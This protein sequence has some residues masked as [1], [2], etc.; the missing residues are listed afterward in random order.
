MNSSARSATRTLWVA[1]RVMI[2]ATVVLG[3]AYP[4]AVTGI[5]R[6]ALPAQAGGSIVRAADGR[7][8]GSSLIGQSFTDAHG[9]P[10]ARYFQSRPSAAGDGYDPGSSGGSNLGPSSA[11]LAARVAA[12]RAQVARFNGVVPAAVPSDAVTASG[13]GLDPDISAAYARIQIDRVARSRG[14][15]AARVAALVTRY[16]RG[17]LAGFSGP[18]RVNVLGLNLALDRQEG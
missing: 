2:A 18:A 10:I 3:V 9:R 7:P 13:S 11:E 14:L 8:A 4:L 1:V 12:R 15:P 17:G 16:T 5:G 6:W